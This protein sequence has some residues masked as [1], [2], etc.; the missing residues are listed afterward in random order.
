MKCLN[1]IQSYLDRYGSSCIVFDGYKNRLSTKDHQ[2]GRQIC[3]LQAENDANGNLSSDPLGQSLFQTN[4]C[5]L[6]SN[7]PMWPFFRYVTF[8]PEHLTPTH[9]LVTLITLNRTPAMTLFSRKAD[10]H[11]HCATYDLNGL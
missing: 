7:I 4:I 9:L 6:Q 11:P 3:Q 5:Q 10:T 1:S 8:F 2:H